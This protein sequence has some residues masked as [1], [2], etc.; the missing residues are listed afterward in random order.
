MPFGYV[1]ILPI[2]VYE[3]IFL[4]YPMYRGLELGLQDKDGGLSLHNYDRL[5][6]DS[7]FWDTVRV[8]LE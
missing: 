4:L 1:L 3:G 8:T 7:T 5:I 2:L 6:H